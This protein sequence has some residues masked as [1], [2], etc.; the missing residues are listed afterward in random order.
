MKLQKERELLVLL[1]LDQKGLKTFDDI[2]TEFELTEDAEFDFE[3]TLN[4]LVK[5]KNLEQSGNTWE[6]TEMGKIHFSDLRVEQY[7]D[8]NKMS[9]IVRA[10]IIVT[11]ILAFMKVFPKMFQQ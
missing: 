1:Y 8:M 4:D 5:E 6:M 3:L 9:Y 11:A 10:V 2:R 7:D